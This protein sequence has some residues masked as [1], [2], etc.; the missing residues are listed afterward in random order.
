MRYWNYHGLNNPALPN[1]K[2]IKGAES[3][4]PLGKQKRRVG[5]IRKYQRLHILK[6]SLRAKAFNR[7]FFDLYQNFQRNPKGIP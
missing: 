6:K 2:A 1:C 5:G 7:L 3:V 4:K